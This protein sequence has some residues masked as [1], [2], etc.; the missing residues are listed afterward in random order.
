MRKILK[1]DE[2]NVMFHHTGVTRFT[3]CQC[4]KDCSCHED[5]KPR[6][7]DYYSVNRKN[8]K[9]TI[10]Q[11]LEEANIRWDFVSS[12]GKKLPHERFNRNT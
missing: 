12:L 1:E 2:F 4:Y 3:G 11:T 8:K 6:T 10:H 7:Y 5:F 9:T